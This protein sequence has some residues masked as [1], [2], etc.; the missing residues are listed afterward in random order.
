MVRVLVGV[1]C[2]MGTSLKIDQGTGSI[3]ESGDQGTFRTHISREHPG[4]STKYMGTNYDFQ[5]DHGPL[6]I[7]RNY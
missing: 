4:I 7:Y 5:R 6:L 3:S 1:F 2:N